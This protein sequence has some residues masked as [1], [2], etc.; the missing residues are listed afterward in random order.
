MKVKK[1]MSFNPGEN[2]FN[3][4]F[5]NMGTMLGIIN[6][7]AGEVG[8]R[9]LAMMSN[10]NFQKMDWVIIVNEA[11]GERIRIDFDNKEHSESERGL[12]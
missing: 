8:N 2:A 11:T 1:L 5:S 12:I 3:Q 7:G 6:P 9:I 4:D 10:H